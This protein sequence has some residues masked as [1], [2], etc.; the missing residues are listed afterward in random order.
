MIGWLAGRLYGNP[1][2]PA[3]WAL[4]VVAVAAQT[5]TSWT[6]GRVHW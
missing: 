3:R 2:L 6:A 5:L 4:I 1:D